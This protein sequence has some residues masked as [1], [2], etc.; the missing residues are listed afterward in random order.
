MQIEKLNTLDT[1]KGTIYDIFATGIF[2][3]R[4]RSTNFLIADIYE[5]L[6]NLEYYSSNWSKFQLKKDRIKLNSDFSKSLRERKKE[7]NLS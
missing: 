3:Y 7:L 6:D 5:S 4:E 1:M 2:A